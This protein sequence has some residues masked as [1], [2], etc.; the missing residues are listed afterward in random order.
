MTPEIRNNTKA[1]RFELEADGHIG[2]LYY[3][4]APG[5]ITFTHTEVPSEIGGRGYATRLARHGLDYARA[6]H[7]R[8]IPLCAVVAGF[9]AKNP[10][11]QELLQDPA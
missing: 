8:I 4:S 10:E 9:I 6:H 11:Y 2:A 5:V 3:R 1:R 7:L